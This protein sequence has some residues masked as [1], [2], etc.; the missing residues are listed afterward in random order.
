M[1]LSLFAILYYEIHYEVFTITTLHSKLHSMNIKTLLAQSESKTLEF[2]RDLSSLSG[3]LKT[4]TAFANTAGGTIVIGIEDKTKHI[5]GIEDPLKNEER[6]ISSI[7]DNITPKLCPSIEIISFQNTQLLAIEVYPSPSRPH[8][9]NKLGPDKGVYI[10]VGST[11]RIADN[12]A[13]SEIK[14]VCANKSFDEEPMP[15]LSSEAIDFRAA[16]ELFSEQRNLSKKDLETL[17]IL[18]SHQGKVVPTIGGVLLFGKDRESYFPDAWI[19]AGSFKGQ[20]KS[21]IID[22]IEIHENLIQSI[23]E[24]IKFI[25]KN[26]FHEF[27]IGKVKRSINTSIPQ[28]AIREAL[29]NA[30]V[31][32]DYG[33]RGSPI[34][35]AV[36]S[37]RIEFES[38]GLLPF[39][40]TIPDILSGVSKLRNRVIGRV[41]SELGFIEQWG[42]G[43]QRM[44]SA[45]KE[46]GLKPPCFEEIGTH[47]RATLFSEVE[48]APVLDKTDKLILEYLKKSK[49]E[50]LSTQDIAN[51]IDLSVRAT[52]T[53]L[54]KLIDKRLVI[55]IATNPRDPNKKYISTTG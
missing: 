24:A 43:I 35:V 1:L 44:I 9:L 14:R 21:K 18:T 52:R 42:S 15:S 8:S 50:G 48:T 2:K 22:N 31:H 7:Y 3:I 55:E 37:N 39:G 36:F 34:R 45:C 32:A 10:R 26:L 11:N 38:P 5:R 46:A 33:Q 51:N 17:Q 6:I 53:R 25:D 30:I 20:D 16:S 19:K 13:I 12:Q 47:F 23:E 54:I 41:F 49:D 40:I 29:I 27:L 4:I 28:V